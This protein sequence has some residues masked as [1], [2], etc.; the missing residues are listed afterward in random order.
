MQWQH[1]ALLVNNKPGGSGPC[2]RP[3][4]P[5]EH[6]YRMPECGLHGPGEISRIN[7]MVEV[8]TRFALDQAIN[9]LSQLIDVIAVVNLDDQPLVSYELTLIKVSSPT[10]QIREELT[11]IAGLFHAK[12]VD[13][14]PES[15]IFRLTGREDHIKALLQLLRAY[16]ILEIATTGQISLGRGPHTVKE[17]ALAKA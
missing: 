12:I 11:N 5:A 16:T 17:T 13:V 10:A 8:D 15:L 3:A 6:Q 1:L 4:G 9:Q 7:L 2:G 14:Y